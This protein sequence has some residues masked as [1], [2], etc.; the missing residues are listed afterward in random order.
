M[1]IIGD[2]RHGVLFR[3]YI[4]HFSCMPFGAAHQ[5]YGNDLTKKSKKE[6][7]A[8]L[9]DFDGSFS[10]QGWTISCLMFYIFE[11]VFR[12]GKIN[13]TMPEKVTGTRLCFRLSVRHGRA[14]SLPL[15]GRTVIP[16]VF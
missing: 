11:N 12:Q 15:H 7:V 5:R 8:K 3:D 6:K 10:V 1:A 14:G 4:Q 2:F 16:L 13:C 9:S